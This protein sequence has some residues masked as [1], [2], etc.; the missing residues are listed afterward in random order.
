MFHENFRYLP[1][2]V[3]AVGSWKSYLG[4]AL[5]QP[6]ALFLCSNPRI[7]ELLTHHGQLGPCS[8]ESHK[9]HLA[10]HM[11]FVVSKILL[12]SLPYLDLSH[13]FSEI[14]V[15]HSR[16]THTLDGKEET[17]GFFPSE[18]TESDF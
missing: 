6:R 13:C 2:D 10:L 8:S 18:H 17:C 16:N 11:V 14:G 4:G 15:T 7:S 1:D 5:E 9:E 3:A 12:F